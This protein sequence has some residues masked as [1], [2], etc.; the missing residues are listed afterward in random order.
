MCLY[1]KNTGIAKLAVTQLNLDQ[2]HS[3]SHQSQVIAELVTIVCVDLTITV[4]YLIIVLAA[5]T[6]S[7]SE[8]NVPVNGIYPSCIASRNHT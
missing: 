4:F 8:F 7:S 6:S 3:E 5:E 1:I 2:V